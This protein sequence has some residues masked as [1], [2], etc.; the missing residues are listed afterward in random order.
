MQV[1]SLDMFGLNLVSTRAWK[2]L[3]W[4]V[5]LLVMLVYLNKWVHSVPD[6]FELRFSSTYV[7]WERVSDTGFCYSW[8]RV[9]RI[10]HRHDQLQEGV[11][12]NRSGSGSSCREALDVGFGHPIQRNPDLVETRILRGCD[13]DNPAYG[14]KRGVDLVGSMVIDENFDPRVRHL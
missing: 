5:E 9:I 4:N 10:P 7:E 13:L 1:G 6:I 3:L 8:L 14:V 11:T 2:Q 12:G